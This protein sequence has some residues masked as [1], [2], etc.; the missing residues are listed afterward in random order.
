[1]RRLATAT[2]SPVTIRTA[3]RYLDSFSKICPAEREQFSSGLDLCDVGEHRR[4]VKDNIFQRMSEG[5]PARARAS[6][7]LSMI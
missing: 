1:M 6:F 3:D 5:V 7:F 4:V 2:V